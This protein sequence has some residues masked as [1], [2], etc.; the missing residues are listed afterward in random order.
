[1]KAT[2]VVIAALAVFAFTLAACNT[3]TDS[4]DG[5]EVF[6]S[7]CASCHGATGQPT[8][9]NVERLGVRDLTS[10]EFRKRITREL[11]E[12]QVRHGS[13]N[14]LMPAF[15]GVLREDQITSVAT[16]VFAR[17]K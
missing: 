9:S 16:Y 10:A 6:A 8:A 1:M 14:Q 3:A 17:F 2:G 15:T 11:V 5:A 13:K 4:G 12:N 7:I